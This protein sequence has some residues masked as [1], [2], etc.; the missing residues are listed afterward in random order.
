MSLLTPENILFLIIVTLLLTN[1]F[2]LLLN[3]Y[4]FKD[5]IK[6][7]VLIAYILNVMKKLDPEFGTEKQVEEILTTLKK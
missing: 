7:K 1:L 2:L 6:M 5:L 3:T 4:F